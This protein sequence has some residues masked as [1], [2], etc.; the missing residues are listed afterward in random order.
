MKHC[1]PLLPGLCLVQVVLWVGLGILV[2]STHTTLSVNEE[3]PVDL[4]KEV[5][6]GQLGEADS[7]VKAEAA[8]LP[9]MWLSGTHTA[10]QPTAFSGH[11]VV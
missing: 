1:D 7:A 4:A 3:I 10:P 6:G 2:V 5:P 9:G 11:P 8:R